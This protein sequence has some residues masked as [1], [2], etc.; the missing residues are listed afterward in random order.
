MNGHA[1]LAG[2]SARPRLL[3]C[4]P[5]HFAVTYSI[6]PWMDPRSWAGDGHLHAEAERQWTALR[7]VLIAAGAAVE[8]MEPAP[9]LPDLVFTA[10]AA[11]VLNRKA[12]LSRFRHPER[13]NEEPIFA[14][15][16]VALAARGLLDEVSPVPDGIILEGAGDCI[17]DAQ[18]RLFWLG[19]G[20]R[21]DAAAASFLERQL[22]HRCLPLP[23]ADA[24][25]Y[26]LDTALCALP[27]GS[28]MY[29]P[30]AF[31]PAALATLET[32]VAPEH[33]IA[34][35]RVDAERFAANAVCIL[36]TIV[37]SSC[38]GSLRTILNERGYAVVETPLH[39]FLRSG[40]SACCLTLR[41]DHHSEAFGR[42]AEQTGNRI[43]GVRAN[44]Q[45]R[46]SS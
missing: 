26:H 44:A 14:A 38:G 43:G 16:F 22:G 13:R 20:F 2:T 15:R 6:N 9:D 37:L 41:L 40:G 30:G 7:H 21:S 8:T 12:V 1:T 5:R 31:T 32:H 39:A 35:D 11:V 19:C 34:L 18:R 17:W 33:R 28:V 42:A 45:R 4:P 3:M 23:L 36:N 10:N 46:G 25:F 24:C 29:Y 27:C